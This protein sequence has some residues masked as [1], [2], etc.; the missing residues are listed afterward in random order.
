MKKK[1]RSSIRALLT[2]KRA[3]KDIPE[4]RAHFCGGSIIGKRWIVTAAHCITDTSLFNFNFQK[5]RNN[6]AAYLRNYVEKIFVR[7]GTHLGYGQ[8]NPY[9][10]VFD[11][12]KNVNISDV[13]VKA[14]F[15][16]WKSSGN[17]KRC[18]ERSRADDI[19]PGLGDLCWTE[20]GMVC[21]GMG[22]QD[23]CSGDSG[24]PLSCSAFISE[25][26][27][28]RTWFLRGVT[29][30]GDAHCGSGNPVKLPMLML[31]ST[32]NGLPSRFTEWKMKKW[33]QI[34]ITE[35]SFYVL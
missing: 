26:S 33:N 30:F 10:S 18:M 24:G 19:A 23:T 1:S 35:E 5:F 11:G 13:V 28:T 34:R 20:K 14:E 4:D 7:V 15:C 6:K 31:T 17:I 16:G 21:A 22:A 29:S 12:T 25:N 27:T 32:P 3:A 9:S 2:W 8:Q